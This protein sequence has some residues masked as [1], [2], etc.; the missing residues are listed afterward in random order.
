MICTLHLGASGSFS[1]RSSEPDLLGRAPARGQ[2]R[3]TLVAVSLLPHPLP[4]R[5]VLLQIDPIQLFE[6]RLIGRIPV[7]R[8]RRQRHTP[9]T[10]QPLERPQRRRLRR[11]SRPDRGRERARRRSS[12]TVAPSM[13]PFPDCRSVLLIWRRFLSR[14][15][16]AA[17]LGG[18]SHWPHARESSLPLAW[19]ALTRLACTCRP[20]SA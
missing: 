20:R 16:H 18:L 15:L 5:R 3:G 9:P 7:R 13:K 8:T 14:S 6:L 19:P 2:Q 4:N 11:P 12:P 1:T 10:V 17:S